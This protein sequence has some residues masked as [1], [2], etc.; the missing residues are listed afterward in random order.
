M[1]L[2]VVS[3]RLKPE[4]RDEA[5]AA[6]QRMQ[7]ASSREPGCIEYRFWAALDDP[8][9][10]L[11]FERWSDRES[12]ETHLAQGHTAEFGA[13]ISQFID[14]APSASQYDVPDA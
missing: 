10:M 14:G 9:S 3:A 1:V 2:V 8:N 13:A 12:L 7:E 6:A 11:L 5:V 4:A